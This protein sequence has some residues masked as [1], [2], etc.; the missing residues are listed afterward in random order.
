MKPT[1]GLGIVVRTWNDA[2]ISRRDSDGYADATAMCQANGKLWG[3]YRELDRTTA[4]IEALTDATGLPPEQLVISTTTGPNHLRG[5]WI[6]S[7]LAVDL[8]RW[9]SP[10]FAVWMDGW[11]LEAVAAPQALKPC[12]RTS[13]PLP[14][15]RIEDLRQI[16]S[17]NAPVTTSSVLPRL[18][19]QVTLSNQMALAAALRQFG[20]SKRRVRTPQ[21]LQWVFFPPSFSSQHVFALPPTPT[22]Q[23]THGIHVVAKNQR[24]ANYLIAMAVEDHLSRALMSGF[25]SNNQ[26]RRTDPSFQL[27]LLP[28]AD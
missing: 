2:P 12:S 18:G 16:L 10:A 9:I 21:G 14:P 11:F 27:H 24:H 19:L 4:Y 26:R 23:L 5:T 22:P 7:R 25:V 17:S 8:A 1:T 20:Y 13:A 6:H 28:S 3:H 15:F